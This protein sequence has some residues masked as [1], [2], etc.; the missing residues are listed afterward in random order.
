MEVGWLIKNKNKYVQVRKKMGGGVREVDVAAEA[1]YEELMSKA[2]ELFFPN[3]KLL[4]AVI[5]Q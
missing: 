3:G 4:S 5:N 2:M 1:G